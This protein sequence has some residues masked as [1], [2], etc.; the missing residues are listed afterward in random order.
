MVYDR[1][2][3]DKNQD[4]YTFIQRTVNGELTDYA[5][6]EDLTTGKYKDE[7]FFLFSFA[8]GI[9]TERAVATRITVSTEGFGTKDVNYI[10]DSGRTTKMIDTF[11][12]MPG[13]A[14]PDK[15]TIQQL[16]PHDPYRNDYDGMN[17]IRL[18]LPCDDY[19]DSTLY[20]T[21]YYID[22]AGH[23]SVWFYFKLNLRENE[24]WTLTGK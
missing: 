2:R 10:Y 7:R 18:V 24:Y 3:I 14:K 1:L 4:E 22:A 5:W 21:V 16:L 9:D 19:E 15:K 11:S 12:Q 8:Y 20:F 13:A 23:E 6:N 17:Y